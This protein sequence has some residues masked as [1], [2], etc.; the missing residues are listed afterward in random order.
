MQPGGCHSR[1]PR[2]LTREAGVT[3]ISLGVQSLAPHVLASLGRRHNP[4]PCRRAIGA[5]GEVGF[6]SFSVDLIYGAR[7]ETEDDWAATL[8][9]VLGLDPRPRT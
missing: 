5:I 9:G 1:A 4:E 8:D 2:H 3:R 7:D 6:A